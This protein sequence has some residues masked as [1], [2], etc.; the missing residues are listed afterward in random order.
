MAS[1]KGASPG[2]DSP[3]AMGLDLE[4]ESTK[5]F[6]LDFAPM[7]LVRQPNPIFSS[8]LAFNT[9]QQFIVVLNS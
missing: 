3:V 7:V 2:G 8:N 5:Y 4:V 9:I 6:S 1:R